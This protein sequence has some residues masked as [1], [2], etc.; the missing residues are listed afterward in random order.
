MIPTKIRRTSPTELSVEWD[1]G[2][3]GRYSLQS[4][5][6][7]CPCASCAVESE[8]APGSGLLPILMPGRNELKA[9][10]TVGNYALHLRWGDGHNSG[11]Y[12]F[13]YFRQICECDRCQKMSEE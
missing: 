12:A 8:S 9:I 3:R 10:E 1:D 4:L 5:R 2:H 6:R 13:D 7:Y 11:L